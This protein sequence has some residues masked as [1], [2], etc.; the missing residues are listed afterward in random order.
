[1][2]KLG[3]EEKQNLGKFPP[4]PGFGNKGRPVTLWANYYQVNTTIPTIYKYTMSIK[5]IVA[6]SE[7]K[8][9]EPA[10]AQPK[11]KGKGKGKGK[12]GKPK[13]SG[14]REVK[15]RKLFL[16]I[17]ETLN[18]LTKKDK[19]L[20]LATEFKS[21][22]ISLRKLDL[23][24]DNSIQVNLP[25]SSNPDKTEVF[26][27]TLHG[28]AEARVDE[29]LK[30]VKSTTGALND[31]S[32]QPIDDDD[33]AKALAFPKFPDVVDALNVIFGFGPRSNEDI[34]AVGSS[35][36]FSFKNGGICRDMNMQGRPLQA[37]RGT[38]QS[39]RL[40]TGRILLNANVTHGIFKISGNCATIFQGLHVF[41]AKR[42]DA[43]QMRNL[44]LMNKF[45]PKTRVLAKMKFANGKEV[46]RP[47]AIYGLAYKPEIERASHG[48][49][50][51]QFQAGY[52]FPGPHNVKFY[53]ASDS[54]GGGAYTTVKEF[55]RQSKFS[56]C[57]FET[58]I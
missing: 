58:S 39:V 36:F 29:M 26:E 22:L 27:V 12:P 3:V 42:T 53:L 17:K 40:G 37:V 19:N 44:R 33:A 11:G 15:G 5:E 7:E 13:K 8:T 25:S 55:Y 14:S 1:M 49:H 41:A 16:V 47:K 24:F 34:S 23:G 50:P 43:P 4:R 20:V 48:E 46:R 9:D 54:S 38:F 6:E 32:G 51:P 28:P 2:S 30:Y 31:T 18:E 52:D 35:R 45:L 21:Q 10:A 57:H 56:S